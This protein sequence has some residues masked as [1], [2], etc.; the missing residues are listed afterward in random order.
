M[1]TRALV[2][3]GGGVVGIAWEA[4][5]LKG[6]REGG[7]DPG[8]ADLVV[9]TSAGSVV[10]AQ[11]RGG[12]PLDELYA[13]QFVPSDGT[14]ERTI[15]GDVAKLRSIFGRWTRAETMTPELAATIGRFAL[16]AET[17]SEAERLAIFET[18]LLAITDWPAGRLV[19]TAV[20][21]QTGE[22][23]TWDKDS[24]VPLT[25]A[26]ASSCAV[27]GMF[28]PVTIDGRRY[29]DGGVRS[30]TSADLARD[31]ELVLVVAP[32]GAS[33]EGIGGVSRRALD[34]EVDEL[35]RSGSAVEVLLPDAPA[36]AAFGPNLMDPEYRAPAAEAGL[37][38]GHELAARI[39]DVWSGTPV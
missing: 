13:E 36:M 37:R 6:L 21:A 30:G 8:A 35:R 32:I 2:L 1:A 17:V 19:V 10:G 5:V 38:Q 4:G 18:R 28:P 23:R 22:F 31:H 33:D 27:P 3:G 25:L 11:L 12:R 7:I 24:G 39:A 9:G 16:E 14:A 29:I 20:D 15:G 34:A 26:V